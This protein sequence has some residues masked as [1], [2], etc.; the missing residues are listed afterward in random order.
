MPLAIIGIIAA[1]AVPNCWHLGTPTDLTTVL[2][3]FHGPPE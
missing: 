1:L 3:K 2:L